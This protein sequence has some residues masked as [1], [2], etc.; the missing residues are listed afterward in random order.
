M[1]I[2]GLLHIDMKTIRT[3]ITIM[4]MLIGKIVQEMVQFIIHKSIFLGV[5]V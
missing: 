4:H 5:A 2:I 3:M 1:E